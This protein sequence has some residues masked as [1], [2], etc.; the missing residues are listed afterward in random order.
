MH[1]HDRKFFPLLIAWTILSV[2]PGLVVALGAT[3]RIDANTP[4]TGAPILIWIVGWLAQYAAFF[5]LMSVTRKQNIAWWF[6]A[7]ALPW[8]ADWTMPLGLPY[9]AG[10]TAAAVA[11][12]VWIA[13][14]EHAY[15]SLEDRGIR[16]KGVVL[17]VYRPLMNVVINNVYIKRK[18]RVRVVRAD[19][20]APYEA[21]YDG[22]FMLGDVPSVGESIPLLVDPAN[23]QHFQYDDK[24]DAAES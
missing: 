5:W 10:W 14:V 21:Q 23:P 3:G 16:A 13:R 11:T 2:G 12:A 15:E 1:A 7:S 4:L 8:A 17:Q 20:A 22:L 18:L 19:G 6:V 24:R 9:Q